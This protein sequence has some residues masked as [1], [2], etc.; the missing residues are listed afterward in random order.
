[1][2]FMAN[3]REKAGANVFNVAQPGPQPQFPC[4]VHGKH[5]TPACVGQCPGY[6]TAPP[7]PGYVNS[8]GVWPAGFVPAAAGYGVAPADTVLRRRRMVACRRRMVACRRRTILAA[9]ELLPTDI[10]VMRT[11]STGRI[12]AAVYQRFC[13]V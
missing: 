8:S 12:S 10:A 3:A 13:S 6:G 5:H 2:S 9:A 1:M 11:A 4:H 7:P